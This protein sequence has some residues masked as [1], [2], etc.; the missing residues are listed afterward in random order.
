MLFDLGRSAVY[1]GYRGNDEQAD[2]RRVVHF[3]RCYDAKRRLESSERAALVPAIVLALLRDVKALG[4]EGAAAEAQ[5]RHAA[6]VREFFHN[7]E[8]LRSVMPA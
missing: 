5:A 6:V 3:V 2:P 1:A 4:Q 7:R 8:H